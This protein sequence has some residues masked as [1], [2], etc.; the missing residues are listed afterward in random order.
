MIKTTGDRNSMP[1]ENLISDTIDLK[2]WQGY[3]AGL[4]ENIKDD[5]RNNKDEAK[6]DLENLKDSIEKVSDKV[7]NLN[8]EI[9]KD[10]IRHSSCGI[11]QLK[12]TVYGDGKNGNGV[13]N[14]LNKLTTE[15][16]IKS[17]VWGVMGGMIPI[18][19]VLIIAMLKIF[20]PG[21]KL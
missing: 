20:W 3:V 7:E 16:K 15:F 17:G 18:I 21:V 5:I 10:S 4:L 14:K 11:E 2:T 9:S 8:N 6:E 1:K 13:V 12:I 19:I